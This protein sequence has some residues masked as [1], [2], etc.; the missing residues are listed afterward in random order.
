MLPLVFTQS[1]PVTMG[2][3]NMYFTSSSP[4]IV[5]AP[6]PPSHPFYDDSTSSIFANAS[7]F[8]TSSPPTS[9]P[10]F[11]PKPSPPLPVS[12]G[13]KRSRDDSD[14]DEELLPYLSSSVPSAP[15]PATPPAEPIYGEGM[16]LIRPNGLLISAASQTG[17]WAEESADAQP[18]PPS[19]SPS[20]S[21]PPRLISR[22]SQRLDISLPSNPL[23]DPTPLN[24]T[25]IDASTMLLGI[26]WSTVGSSPA[27]P[28]MDA[29]VRGWTR[30]IANHYP[31][32]SPT[33]LLRSSG[34]SAFLV[35][36]AE[37]YFLFHE[38]LGEARLLGRTEAAALQNLRCTPVV[39]ESSEVLHA[40]GTPRAE[41][42]SQE[43]TS[44][45]GVAAGAVTEQAPSNS[46][47]LD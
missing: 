9:A 11:Q 2:P 29:A 23:A 22:K 47:D 46:M 42:E 6:Q 18:S 17:T 13:R 32:N 24:E 12:R 45:N 7:P 21:Q 34:L 33:L 36:A 43:H 3:S 44:L 30:F 37:G 1:S 4:T 31:L 20:E 15:A 14:V 5:L 38:D 40:V 25:P 39:F 8:R 27:D 16:T 28:S 10:R 35:H 26:G 19:P 41:A